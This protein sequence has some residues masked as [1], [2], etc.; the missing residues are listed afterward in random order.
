MTHKEG[1]RK[2]ARYITKKQLIITNNLAEDL[3]FNQSIN[4]EFF[5]HIP[6]GIYE[7]VFSMP[8]SSGTQDECIR[9]V[10]RFPITDSLRKKFP[11]EKRET[12]DLKLDMTFE[13]YED[14]PE[15][16][17]LKNIDQTFNRMSNKLKKELN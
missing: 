4:P 2:M 14:L 15:T 11:K 5:K 9:T 10:I 16:D 1:K 8:H 17:I 12:V 13:D 6:D 3:G 7:I